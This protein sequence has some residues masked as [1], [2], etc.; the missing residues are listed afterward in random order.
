MQTKMHFSAGKTRSVFSEQIRIDKKLHMSAVVSASFLFVFAGLAVFPVASGL[1]TQAANII[2]ETTLA[3]TTEDIA[4]T[5]NVDNPNGTFSAS[6]P[7]EFTVITNNYS[8][9]TLSISAKEDNANNS[10][11]INDEYQFN[12]ISSASGESDFTNGTWG[13]KP[14]KINSAANTSYLPAPSYAGDTLDVTAAANN[15]ANTY[16]IALGAKADYSLPAGEYSNTFVVTAVGNPVGYQI[17]YDDNTEDTVT[18]MPSAQTGDVTATEVAIASEVPVRSG[19][20]FNNW[21]PGTVTTTNGVDSCDATTLQPDEVLTLSQTTTNIYALKAMWNRTYTITF[22]ANDGTGTMDPQTI[23]GS[24]A[25][26]TTNAYTRTGYDFDGWNTA[27]NGSGTGYDDE[28]TFTVPAS[29]TGTTLYA[30]W[31]LQLQATTFDQAFA[32]AGKSK[33]TVSGNQY[34]QMQDMTPAICEAVEIGQTSTLVDIRDNTIYHIGKLADDRCWL[35]D[36]LALN[37][38]DSNVQTTM[39]NNPSYTNADADSLTSL[40]SGNRTNGDNYATAGVSNWTSSYSYSA[41]LINVSNKDV[42]PT[43]YNGRDEP[44]A[45]TVTNENWKVGVYYN[46]CAA[47]AGSYCYGDGTYFSTALDKPNTAIDAEYDICPSGW[48]MPT[49]SNYHTTTRPDG[50]EYLALYIAYSGTSGTGEGSKYANIRKALRLPL[51]GYFDNGSVYDQGRY[52]YFWSS[53]YNTGGIMY[54]LSVTDRIDPQ[55][56]YYRYY[57]YSVRC[58]ARNGEEPGT[59]NKAFA[60]A[61]KTKATANDGKQ[62]YKMQ[63]MSTS[64]CDAVTTPTDTTTYKDTPEAQLVDIRDGKTYWVAKLLDGKCWMTQ[65]LD[66]DLE[67]TATNVAALTSE[68]TDLT[69]YGSNGY[70]SSNG[71]SQVNNVITWIPTRATIPTTSIASDGTISNWTNDDNTPYSVD[72]GNWYWTDT[73]YTSTRNEYLT[74]N[75][76]DPA[77]FQKD[78]TYTGNGKHGHV[79]NYYNWSAAVASNDSSSYASSTYNATTDNPQNSICPAGWKLPISTSYTSGAQ[80]NNDFYNLANKYG[81]VTDTDSYITANP[82]W[83]VRGGYVY[84]GSLYTSGFVGNYWSS[85]VRGSDVAYYLYFR[86]GGIGP[87]SSDNRYYGRSVRCVVR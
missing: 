68:N 37:L 54:R 32:A 2:S 36:N 70:D 78:E 76:G 28:D 75:V 39:I 87:A 16:S 72:P 52:G 63:D 42:L 80:G 69:T 21:C 56:I 29:G 38:L 14:S 58:I 48:R 27:A 9:Y 73:W 15:E 34:Y 40:F 64:I 49:S 12:S 44:L 71:Y 19:Y 46:Y 81:N 67:A 45:S 17:T 62:Y 33:I 11:L 35:L 31:Q 82:L 1:D 57:G 18:N 59:F 5:F 25:T 65:N 79:G 6:D 30:Q 61:N 83:F 3:M 24:S 66:L 4:L 43:A 86:S 22:N 53:T 51:L 77:K 47:S 55:S 10:K 20:T 8:G 60:D 74:G 23:T 84:S 41:P 26:L 85:T 50:G 13:Y 7:T